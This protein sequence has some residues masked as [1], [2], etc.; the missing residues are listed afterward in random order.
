MSPLLLAALIN[1]IAA[2][3]LGRWLASLHAQGKLVTEDE[4][5]ALLNATDDE[6]QSVGAAFL[7]KHA[8]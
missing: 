4:A 2:P 1:N 7:A 6:V 8:V 3:E 5:R